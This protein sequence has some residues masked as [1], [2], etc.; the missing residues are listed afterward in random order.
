MLLG[1]GEQ[2]FNGF[3]AENDKRC[4]GSGSLGNGFVSCGIADAANDLFP[5]ELFQIVASTTWPVLGLVLL[6]QPAHLFSQLG[7]GEPAGRG[8]ERQH[9][10]QPN[11]FALC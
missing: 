10:G 3:V 2:R 7:S 9:G 8:G 4:H 5:A 1:S 11:A 6:A